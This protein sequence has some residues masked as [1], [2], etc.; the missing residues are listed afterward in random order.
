MKLQD[1]GELAHGYLVPGGQGVLKSLHQFLAD[2]GIKVEGNADVLEREYK[3]FTVDDARALRDRAQSRAIGEHGRV[4]IV[5]APSMTNEAQNALLKTLEEPPAGAMFFLVVPSV[6]TL[7]PT[8]RSRTQVLELVDEKS[9]GL[10]DLAAFLAAPAEKRIDMLKPLYQHD[11]DDERDLRPAV[12]FLQELES[13]LA[14]RL[15]DASIRD[16]LESVY[17]ARKYLMDKGA[18]LKPL[19][20]QVALFVPRV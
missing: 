9:Q 14:L 8:L 2:K 19:L 4:F 17:R 16:G 6:L 20:E 7:L 11:E 18:L 5:V 3:L 10:V 12:A 15:S 1:G 13:V